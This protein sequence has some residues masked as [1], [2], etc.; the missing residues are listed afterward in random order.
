MEDISKED[1]IK[2]L[3]KLKKGKSPGENNIE[4]ETWRLM[5]REI[6]KVFWKLINKIWN[7]ERLE[8]G[9]YLPNF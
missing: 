7:Y 3:K 4:N 8:E 2:Q 1:L 9:S 6:G 5:P